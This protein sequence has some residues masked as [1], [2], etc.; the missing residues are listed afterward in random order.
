VK[1]ILYF[2]I[3]DLYYH[4]FITSVFFNHFLELECIVFMDYFYL[5]KW[6]EFTFS[7][8]HKKGCRTSK[9]EMIFLYIESSYSSR[10]TKGLELGFTFLCCI[11]LQVYI[12]PLCIRNR[13]LKEVSQKVTDTSENQGQGMYRYNVC[14]FFYGSFLIILENF[15]SACIIL[16]L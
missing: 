11:V 6:F 3:S 9:M 13:D 16:N 7:S 14:Q 8:D 1:I 5:S 12:P 15:L 2:M 4:V 10:Q